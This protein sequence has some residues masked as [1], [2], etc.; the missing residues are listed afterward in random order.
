M[1]EFCPDARFAIGVELVAK[2]IDVAFIDLYGHILNRHTHSID[3]EHSK[4]YNKGVSVFLEE[5]MAQLGIPRERLLGAT[6]AIQGIV[7][8]GNRV[9][10]GG[11]L[12]ADSANVSLTDFA[13]L[14]LNDHQGSA[15]IR[16]QKLIRSDGVGAGVA[17]HMIAIPQG[18]RCYCGNYGCFETVLGAKA[19]EQHALTSVPVFQGPTLK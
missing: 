12:G 9:T 1:Y 3:F 8:K 7:S 13:Y 5:D 4:K 11:L 6:I 15:L 17:E 18:E 16:G 2:R 10:F 14:S 19:L